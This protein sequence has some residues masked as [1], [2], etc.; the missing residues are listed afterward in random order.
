MCARLSAVERDRPDRRRRH[1]R[2]RDDGLSGQ[3]GDLTV[4]GLRRA[5]VYGTIV[6]SFT[7]QG[8]SVDALR[9]LTLDDMLE[10]YED[11]RRMTQFDPCPWQGRVVRSRCESFCRP[12][13]IGPGQPIAVDTISTYS[14]T[15][16]IAL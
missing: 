9:K 6:A 1:L 15:E 12:L 7:V 3:T 10:R 13:R 14:V 2:R 5:L 11:Y 4:G 16:R 8:F